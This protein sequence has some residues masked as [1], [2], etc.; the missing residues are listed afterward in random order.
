MTPRQPT[1]PSDPAFKLLL[2]EHTSTP[3]FNRS[4]CYI[5]SDP[6]YAQM[7]LPLCYKCDQCKGHI[8]ADDD[9]C[10]DCGSTAESRRAT[11]YEGR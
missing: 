4:D 6:E 1:K 11:R 5:C 3:I 10:S 8:P 9:V 2:D 7:G